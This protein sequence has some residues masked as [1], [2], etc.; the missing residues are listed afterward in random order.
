MGSAAAAGWKGQ[1]L[2][3]K[4]AR[5]LLLVLLS[6][7]QKC[8]TDGLTWYTRTRGAAPYS[9]TNVAILSEVLKIPMLAITIAALKSPQAVGP[10]FRG[11]VTGGTPWLLAWVGAAYAMQNILYFVCLEHISPVGYQVLSQ[12]KVIFTAILLAVLLKK[13]FSWRQTFA[14]ALLIAGAV[15]TQLPEISGAVVFGASGNVL[16]GC[17]LTIL[18]ALVA[19]LPNVFYEK[20]LK[21]EETDEWVANIQLTTWVIF[22]A[23]AVKVVGGDGAMGISWSLGSLT[24][25]FT[26]FVW[27]IVFLKMLNCLI[28]PASLKYADNIWYSYAKPSSIA[29]TCLV[30]SVITS[31]LPAP[32][33]V[34]G[35]VMVLWSMVLYA[36]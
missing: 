3:W 31:S 22:W 7:V 9:G 11:A 34:A 14:L 24:E 15:M 25:G 35:I 4:D 36:K 12:T 20:L 32:C 5:P 19:A 33:M 30:T 13:R 26:P 18:C 28:V 29:L 16:L 6:V 21:T 23:A 17:L 1:R 27:L 8:A 10:S 2:C